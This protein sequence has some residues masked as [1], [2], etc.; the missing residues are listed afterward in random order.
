M[1][2]SRKIIIGLFLM[3]VLFSGSALQAQGRAPN[4][5][6]VNSSG[7][8]V[9]S[10]G[11]GG[12][13]WIVTNPGETLAQPVGFTWSPSG[14][15]LFFAVDMGG[16]VS[17]RVGDIAAQSV[18]EIGQVN[19]A[20]SGGDWLPDGSGIVIASGGSLLLVPA[21]GGGPA[22]LGSGGASL[23]S[24]FAADR[25]NVPVAHSLSPNGR[26][27]LFQTGGQ[28]TLLSVSNGATTP[29]TGTNDANAPQSGLWSPNGALVAYWGFSGSSILSVTNADNG[30]T[31]TLNSGSSVPM[32][33]LAWQ[34]ASTWLVYRDAANTVRAADLSCLNGGCGANP[35]ES[36]SELLPATAS[37]VQFGG[38]DWVIFRDGE[39]VKAVNLGC[40]SS[41][42]CLNSAV[43]LGQNAAPRTWVSVGGDTVVYT[44]YTQDANNPND[45]EVRAVSLGCLSNPSSC[46]PTSLLGQAVAGLVSPDGAYVVVDQAGSGVNA[47]YIPGANLTYLSDSLGGQLGTGL[48]LARWG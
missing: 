26:A 46:Q 45:R 4:V 24:S 30:Q 37:D 31:V 33:P 22:T 8:V 11:D 19:G 2:H 17:L 48:N 42:N 10:G 14:R 12:F 29:L 39:A 36:G 28:Y 1:T 27:A 7:Q 3:F 6:F 9:V 15:Q 47:L 25:P 23:I 43:T 21:N 5:A 32:T 16:V 44:A 20:V 35:L 18:T 40:V 13:R 41:G 34:P 38:S